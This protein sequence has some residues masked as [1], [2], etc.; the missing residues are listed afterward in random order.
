[1]RKVIFKIFGCKVN[2]LEV[3]AMRETCVTQG[4][5]VTD[6][7]EDADTT[8]IGSCTVTHTAESKLVKFARKALRSNDEM[9]VIIA[10]CWLPKVKERLEE[11]ADRIEFVDNPEKFKRMHTFIPDVTRISE[12]TRAFIKIQEGCNSFC[13]Y[14]I[15]PYMRSQLSSRSIADTIEEVRKNIDAGAKEIVLVGIHLGLWREKDK[16]LHDLVEELI[17]IDG[18]WRLRL[19]SV[20]V[21][22][23]TPELIDLV[24]EENRLVEHLHIPLQ[25]GSTN[26]LKRMNRNYTKEFFL[27]KITQVRA[28]LPKVGIST[29]IIVGFPGETDE[30]FADTLEIV[31]KTKFMRVHAFP[32]SSRSGTKAY[33][34]K[35]KVQPGIVKHRE[36]K[37]FT[38][39]EQCKLDF[40]T[41]FIGSY[42]EILTE[43]HE[44]AETIGYTREYLPAR[45]IS[46]K[47]PELNQFIKLKVR[48]INAEG[49]LIL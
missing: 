48:E 40:T 35:D 45:I 38:L 4:Y 20:E 9:H 32:F 42:V 23:I 8:I 27:D 22:E 19:T 3:E 31:E 33:D 18:D 16:R 36:Q 47:K 37:L 29:D 46:M 7:L 30:D 49:E 28:K 17:K 24:A 44:N 6:T 1:M 12:K 43:K 14:C 11:F 25:A 15:I 26:V 41:Q 21:H 2:Q 34:F 13:S 39:A 5:E 10:G